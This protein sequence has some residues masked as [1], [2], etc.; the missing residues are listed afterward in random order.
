LAA[1]LAARG[2][3]ID[4]EPGGKALG[5]IHVVNFAVFGADEGGLRLFNVLH[6][7]TRESI[8]RREVLLRPGR[9]WDDLLVDDTRR[10]LRDPLFTSL[11][12]VVPVVAESPGQVDLL[13]VTRDIW[14]LRL[15][16]NFELQESVLSALT[17]SLAENNFLGLRKHISAVFDMDLGAYSLGPLYIDKNVLGTRLQLTTRARALFSRDTD[18]FEGTSSFAQIVYPLYSLRSAW[19]ASLTVSHFDGVVRRFVGTPE[20]GADTACRY[21]RAYDD[22]DTELV[23]RVPWKYDFR[24]LNLEASVTRSYGERRKHNVTGG[25]ELDVRRPA[26]PEDFPADAGPLRD[27]F[28][29]DALPRSERASA[30]FLRYRFFVADFVT[31]RD[32]D[33]YDLPEELQVGPDVNLGASLAREELGSE[34]SFVALSSAFAW[35]GPFGDGLARLSLAAAGRLDAGQL[36]DAS[37]SAVATIATPRIHDVM[38]FVIE[39]NAARLIDDTNNQFFSLGGDSGLRGY[40]IGQFRGEILVRANVELRSR[41]FTVWV[42]RWG[43]VAFY[44]VGHAADRVGELS[45]RNDVGVGLRG[46]VPQLQATLFR[47]DLAVPINAPGAGVPRFSAGFSQAF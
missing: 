10:R 15:N 6:R 17:L 26:V 39:A 34:R 45:L 20:F 37:V 22:P 9:L 4:P 25:Y 46:L 11:A 40:A 8:I 27:A 19:G 3:T 28:A 13:V 2:L 30:L 7:T 41:P 1:A 12:V 33:S 24:R 36:I 43:G 21:C 18:E 32:I 16:S 14:S 35:R 5:R 44:D 42:T 38:R 47:F 23:E 31:F 29:R